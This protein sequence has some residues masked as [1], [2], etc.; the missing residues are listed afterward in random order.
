MDEVCEVSD[1]LMERY[2]D[3]ERDLP[4]RDRRRAEGGHQPRQDLPGRL[5]RGDAPTSAPPR[6]LDAIVEDLPSPVK[7]GALR[8]G[9]VELNASEQD[10][11]FAY[12]FKTR[13]DPFAGRINLMRVYQGVMRADSQALNTR[14]HVKERIGQLLVFAGKEVEHVEEFGPGDIGAVAKLKETR[15]G[16][17]LAARDEPIEMPRPKLPA[18]GDGLR[19]GAEEPG[20][21]GEGARLA[22][23]A[24]GGGPDDRPAPRPADRRADRRGPLPGPCR[25]DRRP[26]ARALRRRGDAEAAAR[27]LS[28]DDPRRARRCTGATRS[29]PAAA[30]SS[31]TARSRSS[32]CTIA[33]NGR[34]RVRRQ[35]QGRRHPQLVH[36]RRREG[37]AR[38]DGK[39][40]AR[41][42]PRAG[43]PRAAL[44]RRLPLGRLLRD[45]LQAGRHP[46]DEAGARPTPARFCSSRSCWSRCRCPRRTSAM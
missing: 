27:P 18:P 15:A 29:S 46:G 2:L 41:R 24:A 8:V 44:R 22:A 26:P 19:R 39:R 30:A 23:A 40:R 5:R 25:G 13:A 10:P 12:V 3:G 33:P 17:W 45:R 4:C 42:L 1:A 21:R 6:L 35:H 20:R 11:L 37:R 9:E 36:P 7:H 28:G 38:G 31:A 16:D 14:A 34:L 32:R 43:R